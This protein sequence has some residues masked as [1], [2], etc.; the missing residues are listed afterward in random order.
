MEYLALNGTF[1]PYSQTQE[2]KDH[3]GGG[4]KKFYVVQEIDIFS[5]MIFVRH[6]RAVAHKNSE[7]ICTRPI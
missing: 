2:L 3:G 7:T 5:K 1:V 6:N 4:D